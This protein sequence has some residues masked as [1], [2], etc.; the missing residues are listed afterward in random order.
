MRI[1]SRCE[2]L[3]VAKQEHASIA[4]QTWATILRH[5]P[6]NT[7]IIFDLGLLIGED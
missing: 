1:W 6:L 5:L 3:D 7:K 4:G 2:T